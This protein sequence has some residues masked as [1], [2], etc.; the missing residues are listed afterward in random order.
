MK[1]LILI[2]LF[3]LVS[4]SGMS[5]KPIQNDSAERRQVCIEVFYKLGMK[6]EEAIKV[7]SFVEER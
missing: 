1:Y 5:L 3:S 2:L 7:C 4:C 6:A